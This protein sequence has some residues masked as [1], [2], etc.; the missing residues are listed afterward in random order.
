MEINK[1]KPHLKWGQE[2]RRGSSRTLPLMVNCRPKR[3]TLQVPTILAPMLESQQEQ[4]KLCPAPS[5]A[6]PATAQ[7]M[8]DRHNSANE[9]PLRFHLPIYSSELFVFNSFPTSSLFNVKALF[10]P[11]FS[12]CAFG[13]PVARLSEVAILCYSRINPFLLV[14]WQ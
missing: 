5:S 14:N 6:A 2:A 8:R 1:R 12:G 13:F 7:P 9:K 4:E 11:L 10:S 3:K